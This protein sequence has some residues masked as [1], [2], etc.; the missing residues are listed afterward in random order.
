MK[1]KKTWELSWYLCSRYFHRWYIECI[2]VYILINA[3]FLVGGGLQSPKVDTEIMSFQPFKGLKEWWCFM[4]NLAKPEKSAK[5]TKAAG[6]LGDTWFIDSQVVC[7]TPIF[8][9]FAY[10]KF[11][12]LFCLLGVSVCGSLDLRAMTIYSGCWTPHDI[13][14]TNVMWCFFLC[15]MSN[16]KYRIFLNPQHVNTHTFCLLTFRPGVNM[17][18]HVNGLE[19]AHP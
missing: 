10:I 16:W 3:L 19:K 12:L 5:I 18:V 15:L 9:V 13:V 2:H 7:L 8:F 1:K 11:M 17:G 6:G 14:V 4:A